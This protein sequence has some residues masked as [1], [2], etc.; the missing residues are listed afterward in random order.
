MLPLEPAIVFLGAYSIY[1]SRRYIYFSHSLPPKVDY[2]IA[3]IEAPTRMPSRRIPSGPSMSVSGYTVGYDLPVVVLPKRGVVAVA[4]TP[5]DHQ[6]SQAG[7]P[8]SELRAKC[9]RAFF[10]LPASYG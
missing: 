1:I 10:L 5:A 6:G 8:P 7:P 9:V 3:A 4:S 2:F